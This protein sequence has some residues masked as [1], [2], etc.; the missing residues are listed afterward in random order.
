MDWTP[1]LQYY[2]FQ[3]VGAHKAIHQVN[4]TR[5]ADDVNLEHMLFESVTEKYERKL[6]QNTP[7][8]DH[9]HQQQQQK[10]FVPSI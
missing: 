4:N 1:S 8:N 3:N 5:L 2:S 7:I 9:Q 6:I 10:H